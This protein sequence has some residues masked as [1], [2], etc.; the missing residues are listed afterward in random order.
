[1]A[2]AIAFSSD[3]SFC[4][5]LAGVRPDRHLVTGAR[6]VPRHRITHET[7]SKKSK[8]CHTKAW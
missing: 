6:Q 7:Q 4:A 8:L 3:A 5:L 1:M 2:Q